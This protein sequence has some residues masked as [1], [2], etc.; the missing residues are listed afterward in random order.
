MGRGR[1]EGG[2]VNIHLYFFVEKFDYHESFS[3]IK[4]PSTKK[5]K[6]TVN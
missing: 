4:Q 5:M 3:Y 2:Y 1:W 6:L